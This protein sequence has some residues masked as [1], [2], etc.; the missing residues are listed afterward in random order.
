MRRERRPIDDFALAAFITGKVPGTRFAPRATVIVKVPPVGSAGLIEEAH[1]AGIR[2]LH[3]CSALPV[4]GGGLSGIFFSE[5]S[6]SSCSNCYSEDIDI[7][8]GL[9]GVLGVGHKLGYF[10]IGLQF[11]QYFTG[12]LDNGFRLKLSSSF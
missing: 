10:D 8:G 6:I 3:C 9:Y 12:D 7:D 2:Y 11:H 1:A 5:R 4:R